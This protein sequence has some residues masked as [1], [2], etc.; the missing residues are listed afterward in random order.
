MEISDL[1]STD[2]LFT[3]QTDNCTCLELPN[4]LLRI[5]TTHGAAKMRFI[6][7]CCLNKKSDVRYFWPAVL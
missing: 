5:L 3:L 1:K 6:D 7:I 2:T 4:G